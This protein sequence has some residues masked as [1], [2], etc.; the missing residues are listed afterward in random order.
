MTC[1]PLYYKP[2]PKKIRPCALR[3]RA[4]TSLLWATWITIDSS[5]LHFIAP[6]FLGI[7]Y[8]EK[9]SARHCTPAKRVRC[10]LCSA[11]WHSKKLTSP[12]L[13]SS[14]ANPTK[15]PRS[16]QT[17]RRPPS[18]IFVTNRPW[19]ADRIIIEKVPRCIMKTSVGQF[20]NGN[21][22]RPLHQKRATRPD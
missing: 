5:M 12:P 20:R 9:E 15:I 1:V 17:Q 13:K 19:S 3:T 2:K 6:P 11:R 22:K 7:A 4:V 21:V 8:S 14:A 16:V 10:R 18:L